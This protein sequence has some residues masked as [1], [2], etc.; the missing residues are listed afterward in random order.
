MTNIIWMKSKTDWFVM[1]MIRQY[2]KELKSGPQD[3][4]TIEAINRNEVA[5]R[6]FHDDIK[7]RSTPLAA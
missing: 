5:L 2:I 1:N 6:S 3:A 4:D 7:A